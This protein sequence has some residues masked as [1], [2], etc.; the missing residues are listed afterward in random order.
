MAHIVKYIYTKAH[1][2]TGTGDD[3][4]RLCLQLWTKDGKL[5]AEYDPV[6]EKSWFRPWDEERS[7]QT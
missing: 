4:V 6:A 1:R 2:G 3:P 5:I 7:A